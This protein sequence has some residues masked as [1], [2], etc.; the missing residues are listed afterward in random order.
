MYDG[1]WATWNEH[2]KVTQADDMLVWAFIGLAGVMVWCT[3]KPRRPTSSHGRT[4]LEKPEKITWRCIFFICLLAPFRIN[5]QSLF[6][7]SFETIFDFRTALCWSSKCWECCH[8]VS[9]PRNGRNA[10]QLFR[11]Q[12]KVVGSSLE[13]VSHLQMIP[14]HCLRRAIVRRLLSFRIFVREA[15]Q[16]GFKSWQR[17]N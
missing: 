13:Y 11:E 12:T 1:A 3:W 16:N 10:P 9:W 2:R 17:R 15:Q 8:G 7:R 4:R 6:K 5:I 14:R